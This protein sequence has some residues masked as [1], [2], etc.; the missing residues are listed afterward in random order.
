MPI[1]FSRTTLALRADS[2]RLLLGIAAAAL[3]LLIGLA[4]W[5][6]LG[7]VPIYALSKTAQL[8]S[9]ATPRHMHA[10]F[11]GKVVRIHVAL[12]Q[13]V[14]AGDPIADMDATLQ[15]RQLA[16][17]EERLSALQKQLD[18][19]H[20]E[21]NAERDSAVNDRNVS[22]A[23]LARARSQLVMVGSQRKQAASDAERMR[24][25]AAVG[26]VSRADLARAE[27][28]LALLDAAVSAARHEVDRFAFGG[29]SQVGRSELRLAQRERQIGEIQADIAAAQANR[30]AFLRSIEE[31]GIRAAADG[32]IAELPTY[33]PGAMLRTG[34]YIASIVQQ[35]NDVMVV[36]DFAPGEALGRVRPGQSARLR[37]SGFPWTRYDALDA[38]VER[39]SADTRSG[40]VRVELAL[41]EDPLSIPV[42]HGLP[43]VVEIEV[44]RL[45]PLQF[46]LRTAGYRLHPTVAS[47]RES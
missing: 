28:D 5:F 41:K 32:V 40:I 19:A 4:F 23:E 31:R 1:Q 12:G 46:L 7:S 14:R 29:A 42:Q 39:V 26:L 20:A 33:R 36:A 17:E 25:L 22:G 11:P 37:L 45:S 38:R 10:P 44:E 8:E 2:E 6:A 13:S 30:D 21:L 47:K 16:R 9:Q 15:L 34:D 18:A 27:A 35:H 3:A 43:G 24:P